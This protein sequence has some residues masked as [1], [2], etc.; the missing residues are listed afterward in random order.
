MSITTNANRI[1]VE[2]AAKNGTLGSQS[3][4][5]NKQI[6]LDSNI[7]TNNGNLEGS[8]TLAKR[9]IVVRCGEAD[10]DTNAIQTVEPDGVTCNCFTLWDDPPQ[11]GDTYEVSYK[12][13]DVETIVGCAKEVSTQHYVFSKR[14]TVGDGINFAYLGMG[15]YQIIR[16][17]D[18][19]TAGAVILVNNAGWFHIGAIRK[20][21]PVRGGT[22]VFTNDGDGE[23]VMRIKTGGEVRA[24][25]FALQGAFAADDVNVEVIVESGAVL[26]WQKGKIFGVTAPMV[27][28]YE[29]LTRFIG[30]IVCLTKS[31]VQNTP[32]YRGW[33]RSDFDQS[34]FDAIASSSDSAKVHIMIEDGDQ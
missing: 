9:M 17:G 14:L 25:D 16:M 10:E 3:G 19:G 6:I 8:P 7:E 12:L 5:G 29:N 4:A 24:Y 20:N 18:S 2:S 1:R 27:T 13:D 33:C 32:A 28:K 22:I 21:E 31:E 26:K 30:T 34:I 11:S 15:N 23:E